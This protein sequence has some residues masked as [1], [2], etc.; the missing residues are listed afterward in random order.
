M[1][2]A[3]KTYLI[4]ASVGIFIAGLAYLFVVPRFENSAEVRAKKN[5]YN[6]LEEKHK[7][8]ETIDMLTHKGIKDR[9]TRERVAYG[10][11]NF[12]SRKKADLLLMS[13]TFFYDLPKPN[14][15]ETQALLLD[16]IKIAKN[17][18]D[19]FVRGTLAL[20]LRRFKGP[21]A[22]GM[23]FHLAEN[24]LSEMVRKGAKS[25]LADRRNK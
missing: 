7:Y 21:E 14:S 15:D 2:K 1:S 19:P 13:C 17:D 16:Q 11:R 22:D 3:F 9:A 6:S 12:S 4:C 8:D 10:L 23:L 25:V 18:S 5:G 24:D 20:S